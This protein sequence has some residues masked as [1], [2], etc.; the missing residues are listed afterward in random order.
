MALGGAAVVARAV[1]GTLLRGAGLALAAPERGRP[2][3]AFEA[4]A[5]GA[6]LCGAPVV[7]LQ[8]ARAADYDVPGRSSGCPPCRGWNPGEG[9]P[10]GGAPAG[11]PEK[12]AQPFCLRFA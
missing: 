7:A 1:R 9:R 12:A 2:L 8:V 4:Q 3:A 11:R 6:A 10:A 5:L